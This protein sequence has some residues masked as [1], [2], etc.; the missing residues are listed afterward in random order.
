MLH[1][2]CDEWQEKASKLETWIF[3]YSEGFV[4]FKWAII[5]GL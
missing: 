2:V 5:M 1:L 4:G 3:I